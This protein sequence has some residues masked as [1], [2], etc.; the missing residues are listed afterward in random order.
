VPKQRVS[1]K[2]QNAKSARDVIGD[3]SISR[4]NWVNSLV[5]VTLLTMFIVKKVRRALHKDSG[6]PFPSNDAVS[7]DNPR[8]A[9]DKPMTRHSVASTTP[10]QRMK[11]PSVPKSYHASDYDAG[12]YYSHSH[13]DGG[14]SHHDCGGGHHDSGHCGGW[15]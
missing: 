8:P 3:Q 15:D 2:N 7:H 4:I 1:K 13:Y 5:S 14:S 10:T 11:E 9:T 6:K 12:L